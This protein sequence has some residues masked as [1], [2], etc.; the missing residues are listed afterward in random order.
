MEKLHIPEPCHESWGDMTSAEKGRFCKSCEKVV[1]D[2]T[3]QSKPEIIDYLKNAT[4]STCGRF[5]PGQIDSTGDCNTN[6]AVVPDKMEVQKKG[7]YTFMYRLNSWALSGL[8]LLGFSLVSENAD[9]QRKM[10]KV[11]VRGDVKMDVQHDTNKRMVQVDGRISNL[12]S[13]EGVFNANVSIE[14]GGRLIGNAMTDADGRYRVMLPVGSVTKDAIE[15]KVYASGYET[16]VR[17]S[18]PVTKE[19]MVLDLAMEEEYI[20]MGDVAYEPEEEAMHVKGEVD[21][22]VIEQEEPI[23]GEDVPVNSVG[24]RGQNIPNLGWLGQAVIMETE[25]TTG[26]K[27]CS[28]AEEEVTVINDRLAP[29]EHPVMMGKPALVEEEMELGEVELAISGEVEIIDEPITV[30]DLGNVEVIEEVEPEIAIEENE[31]PHGVIPIPIELVE[32]PVIIETMAPEIDLEV[33]EDEPTN[34]PIQPDPQNSEAEVN[35]IIPQ[36]AGIES[37]LYP[38]P[39][40]D[41]FTIEMSQRGT[42]T[43]EIFDQSGKVVQRESFVGEKQ[44]VNVEDLRSGVYHVRV[45]AVGS[46]QSQTINLV[47]GK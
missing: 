7:R 18:I 43:L 24:E 28:L 26:R 9:A 29:T 10:G 47:V 41:A 20:L 31:L 36:R 32:H 38:N 2:F 37:I 30:Y 19:K 22:T 21:V 33:E 25:E 17:K 23:I 13:K 11:S 12:Y 34:D 3:Q 4:G 40:R 35:A 5:M 39:T 44:P 1:V 8:A 42:Y 6:T 46:E 15:V 45:Q 14:S 16:Q 27:E